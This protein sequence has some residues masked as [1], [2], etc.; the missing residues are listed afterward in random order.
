MKYNILKITLFAFAL[1]MLASCVDDAKLEYGVTKPQSIAQME[2]LNDYAVLKSYIDRTKNPDFKLGS[3]V[4][5]NDFNSLGLV[6]RLT[7]TNFDEITAGNAMKYSSCV[8]DNGTMNFSTVEKF[9]QTAKAAG[10]SIYG[11]T[12]CWHAQQNNNYLNGL[13]TDKEIEVDPNNADNALL[14]KTPQ[15]NANV[16]D[17]QIYCMLPEPL[18]IGNEYTISIR[19]KASAPTEIPFW[20]NT[21]DGSG[22][23]YLSSFVAGEQWSTSSITFTANIAIQKLVFSFGKF[24][25]DLYF[26]DVTLKAKGSETNLIS[27][28]SF[29][30]EDLSNWSKPSWHS[31]SFKIESLSPGPSTWWTNL[32][33]NSNCESDDV[34]CF[35]ATEAGNGPK[36]AT[37][38]ALGTGAGGTGRAI[39]VQSSDNATN[40]WDTQFFVKVP[41]EFKE[42][43][44]YQFSMKVKASRDGTIDSQAHKNPGGYLHWSMV[45]SPSV[46]TEWK[47]YTNTGTISSSQAGMNTIAFNLAKNKLATTYY[48]DDIT[49]EIEE[50]GNSIP[51]TPEEKADT[52]TW[53][54]DNWVKGMLTA[55]DGYVKAWD[56]VNEPLSGSDANGDGLYDLQSA[57]NSNDASNNFYWQ[58]YLGPDYVRTVVKL[59]RQYGPENM[60]LFINDY[61]L[62]SDWDDNKKL[63]SLIKWIE[64]WEQDGTKIDG[65]GTQMHVSYYM[66]ATTQKSKEDHV[67]KMFQL[68]KE[69][70]KLVK[71]SELDMGLIDEKGNNVLTEN[72]TEEQHKAMSNYYKFIIEKYFEIIPVAQRY[73]ITQWATM[74][75]PTNSSWRKGQPIGLWD[76]NYSR[77]HTY[78]GFADG[79]S[80][81]SK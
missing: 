6:Y 40:D 72:V 35:F 41:H 15:A 48:F 75:S 28:S 78:A 16:W 10:I 25:G 39:V 58:D 61:N 79:L 77:K 7:S 9:V 31:Y 17:W 65:I 76:L 80:N 55:C 32:V 42:G 47:E 22:V 29:D 50:S 21:A 70:G 36:A 3:G 27:N 67:V 45:G 69:S 74:D 1:S 20:P 52:L 66:N 59:A 73:G 19:L 53:A 18:V 56:A 26:D 4:L 64:R 24:A 43:E 12:L 37:F 33:S 2:Y 30:D 14:M 8:A 51:L 60:K 23:Q 11:H 62:E 68:L 38:S 44:A 46:T 34:S 81:G 54:L 5:A 13:L 57:T 63:K 49:F 71:I